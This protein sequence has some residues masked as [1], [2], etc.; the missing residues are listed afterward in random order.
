M[1]GRIMGA[2]LIVFGLGFGAIYCASVFRHGWD[3]GLSR[4]MEFRATEVPAAI[5][6]VVA[7]ALGTT[8]FVRR[9]K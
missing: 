5:G 9:K 4:I 3:Y 6:A 1:A 2:V 7:I 8:G